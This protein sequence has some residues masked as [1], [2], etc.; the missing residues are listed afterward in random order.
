VRV[1]KLIVDIG[2]DS[3]ACLATFVTFD[4]PSSSEPSLPF[5][6]IVNRSSCFTAKATKATEAAAPGNV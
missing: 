1:I 6:L 2:G 4:I 5:G 3:F